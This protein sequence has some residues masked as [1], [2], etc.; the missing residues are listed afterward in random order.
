MNA[1][2]IVHTK[3]NKIDKIDDN[4]NDIMS[5]ATIHPANNPSPLVLLDTWDNDNANKNVEKSRDT[6]K[7]W[8]GRARGG[9]DRGSRSRSAPIKVSDLPS[10]TGNRDPFPLAPKGFPAKECLR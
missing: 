2:T 7:N 8:G 6:R 10:L 4:D 3:D 5:I 1:P 9:P